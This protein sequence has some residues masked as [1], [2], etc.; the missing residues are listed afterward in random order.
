M[1][2]A[3]S[4][5]VVGKRMRAV[6]NVAE[7]A[8]SIKEVGLLNPITITKDKRLV[9]GAHR[10][11]ACKELGWKTI[12]AI[13]VTLDDLDREMA[14]I[15]ENLIRNELTQLE[16]CLQIARRK[17]IY[18][19]KH[20]ETKKGTAGGKA[21]GRSRRGEK[22]TKE[23]VSFVRDTAKK[24]GKTKR[25]V[26]TKASV[27]E[28]LGKKAAKIAGTVIED[29]QKDLLMLANIKDEEKQDAIIEKIASG[30]AKNVTEA[31]RQVKTDEAS[32]ERMEAAA[33]VEISDS[34]IVGDFWENADKVAD[35]SLALI[36][37]DP[38]YSKEA[39]ADFPHLADFAAKKLARGGSILFYLGHLQLPAA[40][41]AFEGKL[42]H[43]WTCACVH[44]GNTSVMNFYGVRVGWKPM[45][46]FVKESRFDIQNIVT[47]TVS[48]KTE[49]DRHE[50]QQAEE[51]ALYWIEKLCPAD[52][53]VCDPFLGSGTTAAA[54]KKLNRQWIAFEKKQETAIDASMRLKGENDQTL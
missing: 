42:R 32:A 13:T 3:I 43:W 50:W 10:L 48:G 7:L 23:T 53:I 6:G 45:L 19:I 20:P 46:W 18:E 1:N 49:K 24:T 35:G 29:S 2:V 44:A 4:E 54:A 16:Q 31:A 39:E 9:A 51:E 33:T 11:K 14:E 36:F 15:D 17:E 34:I 25:T 21:S 30:E 28:K 27:G 47:D 37:T 38:P 5:V 12:S 41:K 8:A 26:S 52:G 40:F 22:R